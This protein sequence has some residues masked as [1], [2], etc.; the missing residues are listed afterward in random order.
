M[1]DLKIINKTREKLLFSSKRAFTLVEVLFVIGVMVIMMVIG[2][3]NY[4]SF[5]KKLQLNE[6]ANDIV[7]ALQTAKDRTLAGKSNTT[8]GVHYEL[9]SY[10]IYEGF[11]F[12]VDDP[13]N[14]TYTLPSD[15]EIYTFIAGGSNNVVFQR[16]TGESFHARDIGLRLVSD[17]AQTKIV[18]VLI[19]G[20]I[21]Y[22]GTL[23][24]TD[25]RI[26]DGRHVH[27][28]LGWSLQGASNMTLTF[29][30]P[31]NPNV[32][33]VVAMASF[34]DAG[35]TEFDWEGTVDVNG[36]DQI[37]RI[38]THALDAFDTELSINRDGRYNDKAL[39]VSIDGK[40]IVSFAADGTPTVGV[41]GGTMTVQ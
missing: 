30:D 26:T 15:I 37:L 2:L 20:S 33:Q 1:F 4:R 22:A 6:S 28:D 29:S 40:Q 36:D 7:L 11:Y 38:H 35:E 3:V 27:F 5:D 34:F 17:P 8:H 19:S 18:Q 12:D 23:T 9:N 39:V 31:P 10:T 41:F 24:T 16:L 14:E 21:G 25:T 32:Q 13:N